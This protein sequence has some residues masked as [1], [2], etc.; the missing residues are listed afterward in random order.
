MAL[1]VKYLKILRVITPNEVNNELI[2]YSFSLINNKLSNYNSYNS[3]II[4]SKLFHTSIGKYNL[5]LYFR[6]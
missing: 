4:C 1:F 3:R 6:S 2:R 5:I